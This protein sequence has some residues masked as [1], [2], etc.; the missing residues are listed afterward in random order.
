M[1]IVAYIVLSIV[2]A[3]AEVPEWILLTAGVAAIIEISWYALI[4][5]VAII[6]AITDRK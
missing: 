5:I 2:D 4:I 1:F 6:S 3:N